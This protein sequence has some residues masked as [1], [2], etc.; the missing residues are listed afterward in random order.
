MA[1]CNLW[2]GTCTNCPGPTAL[3]QSL[4]S[5]PEA[6]TDLRNL[7]RAVG[8]KNRRA[9]DIVI[10][11]LSKDGEHASLMSEPFP[12]FGLGAW[13][14]APNGPH[15]PAAGRDAPQAAAISNC[16]AKHP[17]SDLSRCVQ[18]A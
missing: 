13:G 10:T 4:G 11:P 18:P 12:G 1:L 9:L 5:A 8:E 16:A 2:G 7:Q 3:K 6:H 17:G 15:R 14:S